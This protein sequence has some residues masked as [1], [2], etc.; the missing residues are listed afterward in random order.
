MK[1]KIFL[2]FLLTGGLGICQWIEQ[3]SGTTTDL[4]EVCFT[5]SLNGFALGK[6][7]L[8]HTTDGGNNWSFQN[9]SFQSITKINAYD[10]NIAIITGDSEVVY[11]T[12]NG[13][14]NWITSRTGYPY[15][16]HHSSFLN[17][18]TIYITGTIQK[19]FYGGGLILRSTDY[20]I[21][22]D[23]L[24]QTK[25][26]VD[27]IPYWIDDLFFTSIDTGYAI[28]HIS[29]DNFGPNYFMKTTNGGYSWLQISET[30]GMVLDLENKDNI[31]W[32][33]AAGF[34]FSTDF[35]LT[36]QIANIAYW[37]ILDMHIIKDN[38]GLFLIYE[39]YEDAMNNRSK[40]RFADITDS[41][42]YTVSLPDSFV[43]YSFS[44]VNERNIWLCGKDG[45]IFKYNTT[46][47]NVI[48]INSV[49][50]I[51][52]SQNFP[53]PF[54]PVTKIKYTIP[55]SPQPSPYQGEGVRV[56]LKVYDILGNEV[57]T[58]VN[59]EQP[60]GE[61]EVEFNANNLSSGIYF[62][63]LNFGN[64]RLSKKMCLIK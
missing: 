43:A 54:N 10:K 51:S 25:Y 8:L 15:H 26:G 61:H 45:K 21:S 5:D 19:E 33:K 38:Y 24:Y 2:L 44:Y 56:R 64:Q 28:F 17:D 52:L 32:A 49:E 11:I 30:P 6:S 36:W 14:K 22:W 53:N 62:Y 48:E 55:T 13:G 60:T 50:T 63:V 31:I 27:P 58:L 57:A 18:S 37:A 34:N 59:K 46:P 29:F 9:Y 42:F 3:N 7:I 23:K 40:L 47:V 12:R 4:Y 41:L 16:Y 20:G 1:Y 35:G 39:Y